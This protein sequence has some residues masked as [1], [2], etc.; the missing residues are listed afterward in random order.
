MGDENA[1][2]ARRSVDQTRKI[3]PHHVHTDVILWEGHSAIDDQHLAVLLQRETVHADLPQTAERDESHAR[4]RNQGGSHVQ[5]IVRSGASWQGESHFSCSSAFA[6]RPA[7]FQCVKIVT[8]D[9][10]EALMGQG[11][12][13]VD[14]RTPEEFADGHVPGAVNVPISLAQGGGMVPNADFVKVMQALYAT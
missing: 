10:A 9:E 6:K 1:S 8:T 13:F 5:T 2:N 4:A 12:T 7:T 14:V 3:R 11:A